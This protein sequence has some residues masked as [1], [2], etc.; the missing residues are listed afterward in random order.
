MNH[1]KKQTIEKIKP[2]LLT[3]LY[4]AI[5]IALY[6]IYGTGDTQNNFI[7]NEF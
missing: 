2:W 5:F 3:I 1:D 4:V 7:Y 6:L